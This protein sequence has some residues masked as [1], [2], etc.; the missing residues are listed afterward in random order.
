MMNSYRHAGNTPLRE[1]VT[2][3]E[4]EAYR[5]G[6]EDCYGMPPDRRFQAACAAMHAHLSDM[7][8]A[9]H[10]TH[11]ELA[12]EA[13]KCADALLAELEKEPPK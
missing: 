13:V 3:D 6:C 2:H 12:Q 10:W 4:L 1:W 5:R 9:C 11:P 8:N 7:R